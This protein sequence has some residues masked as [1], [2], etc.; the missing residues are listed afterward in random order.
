LGHTPLAC[1]T[2]LLAQGG[3]EERGCQ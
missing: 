3:P 2:V 1:E